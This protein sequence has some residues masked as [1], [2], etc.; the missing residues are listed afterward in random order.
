MDDVV[1]QFTGH[2]DVANSMGG[3]RSTKRGFVII[4]TGDSSL[5]L[6]WNSRTLNPNRSMEDEYRSSVIE[7]VKSE[8]PGYEIH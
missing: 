4:K 3:A 1:R 6:R 8:F 7:Q 5:E 2:G